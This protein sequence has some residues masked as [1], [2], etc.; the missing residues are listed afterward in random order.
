MTETAETLALATR[1]AS[2]R[3]QPLPQGWDLDIIVARLREAGVT[4]SLDRHTRAHALFAQLHDIGVQM[5]PNEATNW[6]VSVLCA[7]RE[8]A[9]ILR[10]L[11]QPVPV[12]K[13]PKV[14]VGTV[15][16]WASRKQILRF[17]VIAVGVVL[18][19]GGLLLSLGNL[20][21]ITPADKT[22]ITEP[23]LAVPQ[24]A[25]TDV[26]D[27]TIFVTDRAD[28][29]HERVLRFAIGRI[30]QPLYL[31]L[32]FL[33]V[34]WFVLAGR[35]AQRAA[36]T[37]KTELGREF[38][39]MAVPAR[40]L[41][42]SRTPHLRWAMERFKAPRLEQ[43]KRL[44]MR[45]TVAAATKRPGQ[46]EVSYLDERRNT[47]Y[48]LLA[49]GR[50]VNAHRRLVIRR[51][52]QRLQANDTS[53]AQYDLGAAV[54]KA[55]FAEGKRD[56]P[57]QEA[58]SQVLKRYRGGRLILFGTAHDILARQRR[59][60][61]ATRIDAMVEDYQIVM[62]FIPV[63]KGRWGRS[64]RML[65]AMGV[66]LFEAS[67]AGV[68]AAGRALDAF[69]NDGQMPK[70]RIYQ[71]RD[72]RFL[73]SLR[74]NAPRY[75]SDVAPSPQETDDLVRQIFGY[76]GS[77]DGVTLCAALAAV[78]SF[79]N[80]MVLYLSGEVLGRPLDDDLS[81]RLAGLPWMDNHRFPDWLRLAILRHTPKQTKDALREQLALMFAGLMEQ[82]NESY[83]D[84]TVSI[85][86]SLNYLDTVKDRLGMGAGL[87]A[88]EGVFLRFLDDDLTEDNAL[89]QD[90]G[91]IKMHI[92]NTRLMAGFGIVALGAVLHT[93]IKDALAT[94]SFVTPT[95]LTGMIDTVWPPLLLMVQ[96]LGIAALKAGDPILTR[97]RWLLWP[98]S[99][100]VYLAAVFTVVFV[101]DYL[102]GNEVADWDASTFAWLPILT[103]MTL[104]AVTLACHV[105]WDQ[106]AKHAQRLPSY[107]NAHGRTHIV[108]IVLVVLIILQVSGGMDLIT[109]QGSLPDDLAFHIITNAIFGSYFA[110]AVVAVFVV[111]NE[112]VQTIQRNARRGMLR[113]AGAMI[114]QV[115][116]ASSVILIAVIFCIT[117]VEQNQDFFGGFNIISGLS[118]I[119]WAILLATAALSRAGLWRLVVIHAALT[120]GSLVVTHPLSD[121]I[122]EFS[123]TSDLL[124]DLSFLFCAFGLLG[125]ALFVDGL[126]AGPVN[127][128]ISRVFPQYAQ[129]AS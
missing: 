103:L 84:T 4:I 47:E 18:V 46:L 48:L 28:L 83:S 65:K 53:Y 32:P 112:H 73:A 72:D 105:A 91:D 62:A 88:G 42:L 14:D 129:V 50:S 109:H 16:S 45:A 21:D 108:L 96:V 37:R 33:L 5:T 79:N 100:L 99:V 55:V 67:D 81:M 98:G 3:K 125:I 93:Q 71:K 128:Y 10:S 77:R 119:I 41:A 104:P 85:L 80:D 26:V 106:Q 118:M 117:L 116:I 101:Q 22:T 15:V 120:V 111:Q 58:L 64:E 11:L 38:Q 43:G 19:M 114:A 66:T 29:P 35:R 25:Q 94:M 57:R 2:Q 92:T 76:L 75:L 59:A 82:S 8:D 24:G 69:S 27:G 126:I 121:F 20:A 123:N 113:N 102:A 110:A 30:L 12:S 68:V 87:V 44:D 40:D 78:P 49:E 51:I 34:A 31:M 23:G 7:A 52:Q 60:S 90:I 70:T 127:S 39:N 86:K 124:A 95:S 9:A 63:P 61:D 56:G 13:P 74:I 36:L 115:A 122:I 89:D 6:L 97:R 107:P 1:H 17:A 54:D